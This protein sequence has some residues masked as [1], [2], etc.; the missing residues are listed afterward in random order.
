MSVKAENQI[1]DDIDDKVGRCLRELHAINTWTAAKAA[2]FDELE[3][4]TKSERYLRFSGDRRGYHLERKGQSCLYDIPIDQRGTLS[5]FR[6][7][8]IR[9]ICAGSW[10]SYSGRNFLAKQVQRPPL[11]EGDDRLVLGRSRP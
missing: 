9:L 3:R 11:Q 1:A 7:K 6:S 10:D 8:R 5:K 4:L 2:L